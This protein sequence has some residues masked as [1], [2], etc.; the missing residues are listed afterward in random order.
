M[1]LATADSP[2]EFDSSG[3]GPFWGNTSACAKDTGYVGRGDFTFAA[4]T[5]AKGTGANA[6]KK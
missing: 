4:K 5:N 3:H 1:D 6:S 2:D